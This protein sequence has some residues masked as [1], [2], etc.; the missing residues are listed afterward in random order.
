MDTAVQCTDLI[1][2]QPRASYTTVLSPDQPVSRM[3]PYPSSC[4]TLLIS[5]PADQ[6][7]T[8]SYEVLESYDTFP[9]TPSPLAIHVIPRLTPLSFFPHRLPW[10]RAVMASDPH[11][12]L[13]TPFP[14]QITTLINSL[15]FSSHALQNDRLR[16]TIFAEV[17]KNRGPSNRPEELVMLIE[18]PDT[19]LP[20]VTEVIEAQLSEKSSVTPSAMC[21]RPTVTDGP[22]QEERRMETAEPGEM[23]LQEKEA[24]A[25]E[26][27]KEEGR[28]EEEEAFEP[29]E[30][31]ESLDT[32]KEAERAEEMGQ[33][34]DMVSVKE[35]DGMEPGEE[36]EEGNAKSIEGGGA[37]LTK[38]KKAAEGARN[39][40]KEVRGVQMAK[41]REGAEVEAQQQSITIASAWDY[42]EHSSTDDVNC[43]VNLPD[44][45]A[46]GSAF[47][48]NAGALEP[49]PSGTIGN[50]EQSRDGDGR[51]DEDQKEKVSKAGPEP[52]MPT[53]TTDTSSTYHIDP[54]PLAI[55]SGQITEKVDD[56]PA[57][58]LSSQESNGSLDILC[59]S[60]IGSQE[61]DKAEDR[62][63][64]N[65]EAAGTSPPPLPDEGD[66][67]IDSKETNDPVVSAEEE[68]DPRPPLLQP[69][70]SRFAQPAPVL[71]RRTLKRKDTMQDLFSAMVPL[72]RKKVELTRKPAV[73]DR[74]D[75]QAD[76]SGKE[77]G[78]EATGVEEKE[79][80]LEEEVDKD[81][82][83]L[84][85]KEAMPD[86]ETRAEELLDLMVDDRALSEEED[87]KKGQWRVGR[88]PG[89]QGS[90]IKRDV[91][92]VFD[93]EDSG[94]RGQKRS[95]GQ[96]GV[97]AQCRYHADQSVEHQ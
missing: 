64:Q 89:H 21:G 70:F 41:E 26:R 59:S 81:V 46:A 67:M 5:E 33:A 88:L 95:L 4:L 27:E 74:S 82:L 76:S 3:A 69:S 57:G 51:T 1:L 39:E 90:H 50:D 86:A 20:H 6:Q 19:L 47:P 42:E 18:A 28:V 49:L 53:P 32:V 80:E 13:P 45:I 34:E 62:L 97:I 14:L 63:T 25:R 11:G 55:S 56:S 30:Q 91:D 9:Y 7:Q 22:G 92:G 29:G 94:K 72:K 16:P 79:V 10:L 37:G 71:A 58:L 8:G 54:N 85:G 44:N 65:D 15:P 96:V 52:V 61:G 17:T 77:K 83:V 78:K 12:L 38:L 60:P 73:W 43:A 87:P 40:S 36:T 84:Q 24:E 23:E 66:K 31:V 2:W 93:P 68:E 35:G 75:L 48:P